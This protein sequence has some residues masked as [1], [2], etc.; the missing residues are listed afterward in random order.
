MRVTRP[1][2]YT[3]KESDYHADPCP[4]PSLS[5]TT[6]KVLL[7]R[8]PRHA[9]ML[10]P[11]LGR[12][13]RTSSNRMNL[14]SVV[15][16]IVLRGENEAVVWV[17]APD[18]KT[19]AAREKRDMAVDVGLSPVL[20]KDEDRVMRVVEA[21]NTAL[22]R[23]ALFLREKVFVWKEEDVWCRAMLDLCNEDGSFLTDVKTTDLAATPDHW[24]RTQMWEYLYQVGFYRRAIRAH[25]GRSTEPDMA[26]GHASEETGEWLAGEIRNPRFHF[27]VVEMSQPHGIGIFE[28][29]PLG[30]ELADRL[31]DTAIVEWARRSANGW[32]KDR[33]RN[34]ND[35][36]C[37]MM[38]PT[39]VL[40]HCKELGVQVHEEELHERY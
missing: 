30:Y 23:S 4:D 34:Y 29:D 25:H 24:G 33:W 2:M 39:W 37:R 36:V 40:R 38:T 8:S 15:H 21:V 11:R 14:G 16:D 26:G 20:T 19:K 27:L 6:A 5:S 22:K 18:F 3:M 1:G 9:W 7:E 35:G 28:P 17:D 10:H 12:A 13:K 31:A 32:E